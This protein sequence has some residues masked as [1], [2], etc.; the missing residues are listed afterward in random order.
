MHFFTMLMIDLDD[1]HGTMIP[2]QSHASDGVFI[3]FW[4][5]GISDNAF[6]VFLVER[7]EK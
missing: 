7:V 2:L 1:D 5:G 3:L 6:C 4:E